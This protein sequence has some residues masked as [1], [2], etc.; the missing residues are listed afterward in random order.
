MNFGYQIAI[1]LG[2]AL[3]APAFA[4][5]P[6]DDHSAH[7]VGGA[8]KAPSPTEGEVRKVDK[9]ANKVTLKHG[10]IPNIGMPAMTMVFQARD[11]KMLEKLKTGDKVRFTAE[12]I[13]EQYV[14]T[15]ME[16]RK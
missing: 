4:Q 7:R 10:P 14:V 8:A 13:G 12:K 15:A 9:A 1:L 6:S 3:A 16:Q 11:P 5:K 2:I